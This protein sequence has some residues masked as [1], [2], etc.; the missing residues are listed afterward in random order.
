ML[1]RRERAGSTPAE[2]NQAMGNTPSLGKLALWRQMARI[3]SLPRVGIGQEMYGVGGGENVDDVARRSPNW[4]VPSSGVRLI[5]CR[6][7]VVLQYST[8]YYGTYNLASHSR[9]LLLVFVVPAWCCCPKAS[10]LRETSRCLYRVHLPKST[11]SW[12]IPSIDA[13][14]RNSR[15]ARPLHEIAFSENS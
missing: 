8:M 1:T 15:Q 7:Y 13:R 4:R 2:A 10:I 5:S 11:F 14:T 12:H 3:E 9:M 6:Q